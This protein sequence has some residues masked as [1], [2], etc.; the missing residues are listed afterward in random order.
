[1]LVK[2][3]IDI[4]DKL[5]VETVVEASIQG[6]GLYEHFGFGSLQHVFLEF[7]DKWQSKEKQTFFWMVRPVRGKGE[8][9][10]AMREVAPY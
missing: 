4:A 1:M 6:R 9:S 7:P 5:G 8:I 2:W 10:E 3:G